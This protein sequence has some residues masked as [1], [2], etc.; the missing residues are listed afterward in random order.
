MMCEWLEY[1]P[2]NNRCPKPEEGVPILV[3]SVTRYCL[4]EVATWECGHGLKT[5]A[6]KRSCR[7][8]TH[9]MPLPKLPMMK[10]DE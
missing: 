1:N 6:E 7:D 5:L 9:W 3:Y 10:R 2:M 8:I 4:P